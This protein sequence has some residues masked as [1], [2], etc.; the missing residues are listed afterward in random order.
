S[1]FP[2]FSIPASIAFWM[3]FI[4]VTSNLVIN[5]VLEF[6]SSSSFSGDRIVAI[7]FQPAFENFFAVAFPIPLDVPVINIVF[8]FSE[9]LVFIFIGVQFI[10]FLF[11][12]PWVLKWLNLLKCLLDCLHPLDLQLLY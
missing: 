1:I 11:Y 3:L 2:N 10:S 6:F 9:F 7:M 8:I 12:F 4:S 5:I